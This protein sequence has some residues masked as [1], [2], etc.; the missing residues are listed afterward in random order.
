MVRRH[1]GSFPLLELSTDSPVPLHRQLTEALREAILSGR[2]AAGTRLP[3][4]RSLAGDLDVSR[5]TV[6]AAF[7]QLAA[8]G[9]FCMEETFS[10]Q[11]T[12]ARAL[13]R[14]RIH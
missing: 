6:V 3:S 8:E 2:L 13:A 12:D 1:Q 7:E 10:E 14:R 5:S 4:T 9:S 11:C